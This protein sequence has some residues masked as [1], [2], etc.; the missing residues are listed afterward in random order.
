[1]PALVYEM[2]IGALNRADALNGHARLLASHDANARR[3]ECVYVGPVIDH[4]R[5]AIGSTASVCSSIVSEL[6]GS[7]YKRPQYSAAPHFP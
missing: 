4:K 7:R 5:G 3:L 6:I 1:M 2:T